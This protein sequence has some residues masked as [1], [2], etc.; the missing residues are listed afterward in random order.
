MFHRV[1][2]DDDGFTLIELLVV[3]IIIGILAGIAIPVF[4]SQ[5]QKAFD[6][7]AQ[8]DLRNAAMAEETYLADNNSYA[9]IATVAAAENLKVSKG[10][11]IVSV[12][13]NGSKGFCLGA[14]QSGGSPL[15][16]SQQSLSSL[17][18]SIV[19]WWDSTGGGLQPRDGAISPTSFGCPAT[20]TSSGATLSF[21]TYTGS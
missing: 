3:I 12:F 8:S 4:L 1:R 21:A 14:V 5:R 15:P 9:D 19:W 16:A 20:N 6:A 7:T 13:V 10:T 2:R 18:P 11:S 17:A